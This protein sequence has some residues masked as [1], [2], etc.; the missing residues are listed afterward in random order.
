MSQSQ[1]VQAECIEHMRSMP[2]GSVAAICTDPPYG[3]EFMGKDFDR[4]GEGRA[5]QEWHEA[6]AR[7]A[8]RVLKP[9]GHLLAFGGTR[10]FHRLTCALEDAGFEIRDCLSWLHGQG[11][12]KSMS[13]PLAI[14]KA[15]VGEDRGRA[16]PMASSHLPNGRY[17]ADRLTG[18]PVEDYEPRSPEAQE[19]DGWG[20][21]LKPAWE[22]IVVARKPLGS[23]VAE[24]VLAHGTGALNIDGC[25]VAGAPEPTRFDPAKH[26][27]EGWRMDATGA[28]TAARAA[29]AAGRWPANVALGHHEDCELVGTRRIKAITGGGGTKAPGKYGIYGTHKGHTYDGELGYFD[30]DGME[31]VEDWRCHADCPVRMLDEQG[32]ELSR[33]F[34]VA[35]ASR[36]ERE[37]GLSG[38]ASTGRRTT[39]RSLGSAPRCPEHDRPLVP[40]SNEYRCGCRTVPRRVDDNQVAVRNNHPTVKPVDLMRWLVRLVT[41]PGGLV[42]DPFAGSGSTGIACTLEGFDYLLIEREPEYVA[43]ARARLAWWE[44][45]PEGLPIEAGLAAERERQRLTDMGQLT[46]ADVP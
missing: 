43:I 9:G 32:G 1:L 11:F 27:H 19:W 35:K 31:T 34:Y 44:Q 25:R 24:A 23:T 22:P 14:D 10:T 4:L 45:H 42:L 6:W 18:N 36:A 5:M 13:V 46:I 28:E 41:P 3:L 26:A 15:E 33:F 40:S 17:A 12:P 38:E 30:A 37:A 39:G 20:T 29:R 7:E 8:L 21:A 16:V 2:E